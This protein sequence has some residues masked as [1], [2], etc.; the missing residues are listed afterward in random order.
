MLTNIPTCPNRLPVWQRAKKGRGECIK[1]LN[2]NKG[3]HLEYF[4]DKT[5]PQ[6]W[7][8]GRHYQTSQRFWL[9]KPTSVISTVLANISWR[10]RTERDCSRMKVQMA[11]SG[12]TFC[13]RGEST[14]VRKRPTEAAA[15]THRRRCEARILPE[16][17]MWFQG[18]RGGSRSP[19]RTGTTWSAPSG[20]RQ[21]TAERP[22]HPASKTA[23][24]IS[25]WS[26]K[27]FPFS[28]CS[29]IHLYCRF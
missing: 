5:V 1:I 16:H 8:G 10:A 27:H 12:G 3:K 19:H 26:L 7:G 15:A 17:W 22:G 13:K 18:S 4:T 29:C 9:L 14:E 6:T 24:D 11:R 20:R 21:Y 2:K 28:L 25:H 23:N